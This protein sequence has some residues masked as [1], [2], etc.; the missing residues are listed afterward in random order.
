[1]FC[2]TLGMHALFLDLLWMFLTSLEET[3]D[4]LF[5]PITWCI[6]ITLLLPFDSTYIGPWMSSEMRLYTFIA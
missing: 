1:M 6:K 2:G 5:L 3:S 4:A